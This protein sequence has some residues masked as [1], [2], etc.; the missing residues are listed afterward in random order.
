M[1]SARLALVQA[2]K[3]TLANGLYLIGL[4]APEQV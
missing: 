4:H 3:L 2:T 1:R